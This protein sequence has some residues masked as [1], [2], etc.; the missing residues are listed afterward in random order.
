MVGYGALSLRLAAAILADTLHS[1][2]L[3]L[4]GLVA[5]TAD[6]LLLQYSV[7]LCKVAV[8]VGH[9]L[10]PALLSQVVLHGPTLPEGELPLITD[11]LRARASA[12]GLAGVEQLIGAVSHRLVKDG[13]ADGAAAVWQTA[14]HILP[15][16]ADR[17]YV[18]RAKAG[19]EFLARQYA[20]SARD[21]EKALSRAPSDEALK[22]RALLADAYLKTGR[23]IEAR[24]H[25]SSSEQEPEWR[26]KLLVLA[27]LIDR[28]GIRELAAVPDMAWAG[29][30]D[31]TRAAHA[32]EVVRLT[33]DA[34]RRSGGDSLLWFNAASRLTELRGWRLTAELSLVASV[35]G[36]PYDP[37]SMALAIVRWLSLATA[38]A[39]GADG[40]A[41]V[42]QL[43]LQ[44]AADKYGSSILEYYGKYDIPAAVLSFISDTISSFLDEAGVSWD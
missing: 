4:G 35:L 17:Y 37:E 29:S 26:L 6:P 40:D 28:L 9:P 25:F 22:I 44:V 24:E 32:E 38:P 30:V 2:S 8:E 5:A 23:L 39:P 18:L 33:I 10:E 20:D 36:D 31:F 11:L 12:S 41:L 3:R 15:Q 42:L 43:L 14:E 1:R 34:A 13:Q 16:L 7:R 27:Y 21:Y 19:A